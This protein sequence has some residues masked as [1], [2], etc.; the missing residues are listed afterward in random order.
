MNRKK[1]ILL[2]LGL[3]ALVGI[4]SAATISYFGQVQMTA[5]VKQAVLLDGKNYTTPITEE[6][7]VAGGESFCRHHWL[8]SQTSVPVE[9]KFTT[10]YSPEGAGITTTYCTLTEKEYVIEEGRENYNGPVVDLDD[11]NDPYST[12]GNINLK[13]SYEDAKVVFTITTPSGLIGSTPE[14]YS[15]SVAFIFDEDADN[16]TDWQVLY[17][18]G[19]LRW[20]F[21]G[22]WGYEEPVGSGQWIDA[23][24][25]SDIEVAR[26][27]DNFIVKVDFDRLGGLGSNYKFGFFI[28]V[29]TEYWGGIPGGADQ[30]MIFFPSYEYFDWF[31][32]SNFEL[33][34][35]GTEIPEDTPFTLAPGERL[36]F[37]ICYEFAVN[38]KPDTYTITTKVEP[39]P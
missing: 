27:G 11:P 1:L 17:E 13:I 21:D 38:I 29:L 8:K 31:N 34:T 16:A 19:S 32:S 5:T 14:T 35:V 2:I 3:V 26:D 12:L 36:D 10:T 6:V 24:T 18:P 37:Y 9:L 4:V 7:E 15:G 33:Q 28:S 39:V 25:V 30:V 20:D 23:S 22:Y